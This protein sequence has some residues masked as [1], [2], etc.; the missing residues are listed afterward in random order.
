M[1]TMLYQQGVFLNSC[2]EE[3]NLNNPELVKN[4]HKE[5]I[6]AG[7]DFI[8]TNTFGANSFKLAKFGLQDKVEQVN[9]AAVEL[10]RQCAGS[11]CY[12][13]RFNR[14]DWMAINAIQ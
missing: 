13:C 10:A 2:F 1:G 12:G 3:A 9:T 11:D 6:E 7:A 4:I 5:Y 8:E 14:A